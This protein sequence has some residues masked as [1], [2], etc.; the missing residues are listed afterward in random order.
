LARRK[1]PKREFIDVR[2]AH[3]VDA[4]GEA[5]VGGV[6]TRIEKKLNP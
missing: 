6:T 1:T 4:I 5:I 3:E 2:A